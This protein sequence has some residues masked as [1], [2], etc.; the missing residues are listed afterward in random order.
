MSVEYVNMGGQSGTIGVAPE[1]KIVGQN[2]S[3]YKEVSHISI[4]KRCNKNF[5]GDYPNFG[6]SKV[7]APNNMIP[8]FYLEQVKLRDSP[9]A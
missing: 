7:G 3:A 5:W 6:L 4:A 8:H 9:S 1:N 2:C